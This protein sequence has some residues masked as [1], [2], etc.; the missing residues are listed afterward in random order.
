MPTPYRH[1]LCMLAALALP[2]AHATCTG[3]NAT[4]QY[5]QQTVGGEAMAMHWPTG[6]VWKR[7]AQGQS[8]DGCADDGTDGGT[9]GRQWNDWMADYMPKSFDGQASWGIAADITADRLTSGAWRMP[10]KEELRGLTTDCTGSTR[11]NT[12]VFQNAPS[13]FFWS[14]S[15]HA[16][17]SDGAWFVHFNH[18][19]VNGNYRSVYHRGRLVRGGQSFALLSLPPGKNV[20]AGQQTEF[21]AITLAPLGL[22]G[23]SWGGARIE[24]EGTPAFQVNSTGDWVQQAIVK[25]GDTLTVRLT[26]GAPGS[27]RA[28]Q[29]ARRHAHP[30]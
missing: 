2:A 10:Y 20:A 27:A 8:G 13:S 21:D 5:I 9:Y 4:D 28:R 14:G 29:R 12:Q 30:A 26:A 25:S 22:L 11:I 15:P 23:E 18:G 3:D 17:D 7:C 16:Y 24:G 19:S 1:A 6:L